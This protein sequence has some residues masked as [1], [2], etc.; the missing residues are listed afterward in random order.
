MRMNDQE[1][2]FP[3]TFRLK[4][5]LTTS[6]TDTENEEQLITI[7]NALNIRYL[8]RSKN[9]SREDSY[10]SFTYEVTLNDRQTMNRLYELLKE[11]ENLKFAL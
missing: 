1:I 9:K 3:V 7:F 5:V 4:A 10:V 6:L 2:N 11:I 8:Y